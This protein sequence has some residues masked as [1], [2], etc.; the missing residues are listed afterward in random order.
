[1]KILI[2]I[3]LVVAFYSLLA[4]LL[5]VATFKTS[6]NINRQKSSKAPKK[7][8]D[9][10]ITSFANS[11]EKYIPITL[12]QQMKLEKLLAS[13]NI[14]ETPKVYTARNY[15]FTI[16]VLLI[17]SPLYFFSPLFIILGLLCSLI[18]VNNIKNNTIRKG[19]RRRS[20]IEKELP[21]FTSN[22]ANSIKTNRN[23][24]DILDTYKQSYDTELTKE[25]SITLA[26]MRTGSHERAL[27]KLET[28]VNSP[29]MSELV[30]GIISTMRGDN[31]TMYF[32]NLVFKMSS[33]FEQ[34]LKA[35]ALRIKP[36]LGLVSTSIAIY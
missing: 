5:R 9:S 1:M 31:M 4:I 30:R 23:V 27:Q 20:D 13:A 21:H 19:N 32:E 24:I 14:D 10:F 34:S 7:T 22:F 25:L 17:F 8:L 16:L 35:A 3:L 29:I 18:V 28:R 2:F 11:I 6:G 12:L 26:D 36:K 33:L 15:I